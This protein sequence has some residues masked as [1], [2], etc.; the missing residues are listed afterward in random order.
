[1][2]F[3]EYAGVLVAMICVLAYIGVGF[4]QVGLHAF[5]GLRIPFED[6]WASAM[7]SLSSAALGYLIGKQNIGVGSNV[8]GQ[9]Q[10]FAAASNAVATQINRD[11]AALPTPPTAR[12]IPSPEAKQPNK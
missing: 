1:M 6:S 4:T 12:P 11:A 5:F 10:I 3:R 8:V 2:P 7:L 9:E